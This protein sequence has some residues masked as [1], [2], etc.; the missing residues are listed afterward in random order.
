MAFVR[1]HWARNDRR[2]SGSD[3]LRQAEQGAAADALQRPLRS[4]FQARL[5]TGVSPR[6]S[7]MES[8][9]T[10]RTDRLI[11]TC[12]GAGDFSELCAMHQD[13]RVMA[14]LGG[15]RSAEQTRHFLQ[16]NLD[17]WERHGYGLWVFRH[18]ADRRFVGRGGLRNVTV[19]G[20]TEVEVAY[21]VMAEFWGQG[22]ATEMAAASLEVAFVHLGLG[23][24]VAFTLPTNHASRRVMGK[25][26]FRYERDVLHAGLPHVLYRIKRG[27]H[28]TG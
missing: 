18:K 19:A 8:I 26:G 2:D 20:T 16:E 15:L 27:D 7:S 25:V 23:V 24:V 14:T 21:A 22:F 12:L 10:F 9:T 13:P 28:G 17:H 3:D 11:A 4:R 1:C 6:V 5:G